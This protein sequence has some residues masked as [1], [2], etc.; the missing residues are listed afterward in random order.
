MLQGIDT[1]QPILQIGHYIFS[2][3]YEHTTGTVVVY[4]PVDSTKA[5]GNLSFEFIHFCVI[6]I[7]KKNISTITS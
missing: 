5:D 1:D 2:G 3:E 4:Q 6:N 7:F